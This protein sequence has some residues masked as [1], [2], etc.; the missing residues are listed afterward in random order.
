M[1]SRG[2][3][4]SRQEHRLAAHADPS[5]DW[6]GEEAA[7]LARRFAAASHR[8]VRCLGEREQLDEGFQEAPAAPFRLSTA[9]HGTFL[10]LT[11]PGDSKLFC[12][13]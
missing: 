13:E 7:V 5:E 4:R 10:L 9:P 12:G 11:R 6:D 8:Q 3:E 2:I 1:E